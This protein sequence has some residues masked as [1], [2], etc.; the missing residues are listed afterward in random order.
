MTLEDLYADFEIAR[1]DL[2]MSTRAYDDRATA[3]AS[4]PNLIQVPTCSW[5]GKPE[6]TASSPCTG[7][8]CNAVE[9]A[10]FCHLVNVARRYVIARDFE[11]FDAI[12]AEMLWKLQNGGAV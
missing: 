11:V 2:L 6:L 10:A 9:K 1:I 3:A 5:I 4:L 12:D 8:S 7:L